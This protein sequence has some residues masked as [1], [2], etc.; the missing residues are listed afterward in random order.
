MSEKPPVS[1]QVPGEYT[2]ARLVKFDDDDLELQYCHTL[3]NLGKQGGMSGTISHKAQNKVDAGLPWPAPYELPLQSKFAPDEFVRTP[4]KL[5]RL[6]KMIDK[7][8]WGTFPADGK[9]DIYEGLLECNVQDVKGGAGQCFTPRPLIQAMVEVMQP[10]VQ[11]RANVAAGRMPESTN[12]GYVY[13]LPVEIRI[14]IRYLAESS[15]T[16]N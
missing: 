10:A 5:E 7:E 2:R 9:G 12:S 13:L 11:G 16:I 6:I 8:Q 14:L 15:G 3:E 1:K 4:A